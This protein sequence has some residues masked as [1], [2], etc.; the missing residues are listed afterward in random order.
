MSD[1]APVLTLQV[2]N[3]STARQE[4]Q[5]AITQLAAVLVEVGTAILAKEGELAELLTKKAGIAAEHAAAGKIVAAVEQAAPMVEQEITAVVT[6][7]KTRRIAI[8]G[9]LVICGAIVLYVVG[10]LAFGWPL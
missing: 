8:G 3:L 7:P 9:A 1:P 2:S 6:N 5:N 4:T 10:H